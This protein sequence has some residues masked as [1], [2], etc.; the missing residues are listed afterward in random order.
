MWGWM[1]MRCLT[2][3]VVTQVFRLKAVNYL[4]GRETKPIT[5]LSL[6]GPWIQT[7]MNPSIA[8]R[9]PKTKSFQPSAYLPE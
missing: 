9:K 3:I 6:L 4:A 7:A 5:T 8:G 1:T 2:K